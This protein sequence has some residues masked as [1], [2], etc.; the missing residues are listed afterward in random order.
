MQQPLAQRALEIKGPGS[1]WT[2]AGPP[3]V[4]YQYS[5][6]AYLNAAPS[7]QRKGESSHTMIAYTDL[8]DEVAF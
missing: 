1:A 7:A 6:R 4:A 5:E 8:E 2:A 3:A